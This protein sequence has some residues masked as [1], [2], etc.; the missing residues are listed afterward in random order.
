[1]SDLTKARALVAKSSRQFRR[2]EIDDEKAQALAWTAAQQ[3]DD[4]HGK[5]KD[6][7]AF[8]K[9]LTDDVG[10][11]VAGADLI[12]RTFEDRDEVLKKGAQAVATKI[13]RAHV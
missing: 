4:L 2:V 5:Y 7:K 12:A 8:R 1:M 6:R 11:P 3:L 13:G 10:L 9:A